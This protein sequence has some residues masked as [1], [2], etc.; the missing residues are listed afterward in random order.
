MAFANERNF[1]SEPHVVSEPVSSRERVAEHHIPYV[2]LGQEIETGEISVGPMPTIQ[3]A[4]DEI[5]R[6]MERVMLYGA[7]QYGNTS[8]PTGRRRTAPQPTPQPVVKKRALTGKR[9]LTF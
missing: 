3:Q 6:E 7:D 2:T 5:A 1:V 8:S 4:A 9:K